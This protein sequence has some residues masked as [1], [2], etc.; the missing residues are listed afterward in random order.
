MH[1]LTLT[2]FHVA[3]IAWIQEYTFPENVAFPLGGFD[4]P[5]KIMLEVHF[6]NPN[7]VDG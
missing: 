7:G 1:V 2:S 6:D 3:R 4:Q 5:Y